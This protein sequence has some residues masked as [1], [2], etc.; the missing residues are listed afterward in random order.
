MSGHSIT[1][2]FDSTRALQVGGET[3]LDVMSYTV[4][5]GVPANVE[6]KE[7]ALV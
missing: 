7:E 1:V 2:K 4:S 3:I 6:K 5:A